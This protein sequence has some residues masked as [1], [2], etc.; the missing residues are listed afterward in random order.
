MANL[1]SLVFHILRGL[2]PFSASDQ[3]TLSQ[4]FLEKN[5]IIKDL[6]FNK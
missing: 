5:Y 4:G 3:K 2:A 1:K 6:V